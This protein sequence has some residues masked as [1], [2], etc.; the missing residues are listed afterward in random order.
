MAWVELTM[1]TQYET[2]PIP[3]DKASNK[4]PMKL[5]VT[6]LDAWPGNQFLIQFDWNSVM[7]KWIVKFTHM[8]TGRVFEKRPAMVGHEYSLE[9]FITFIFFDP[10]GEEVEVTPENLGDEVVLSVWPKSEGGELPDG[11]TF[12]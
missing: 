10:S 11:T 1:P 4:K 2:I 9:D 5:R 3:E 8:N 6:G 7:E 12:S